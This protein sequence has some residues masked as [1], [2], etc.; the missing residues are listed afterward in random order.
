MVAN[1]QQKRGSGFDIMLGN[2]P[3]ER[4]KLQEKEWFATRHEAIATAS[5]AAKRKK[6]INALKTEDPPLHATFLEACRVAEGNSHALRDSGRYPL[7]GRGDVNTYTVFTE[8]FR[9]SLSPRGR[10]GCIV[11][12]GIATDDTTKFFFQ[13]I[14]DTQT[15]SSCLELENNGFF[16][17]A[18]QGH[19]VRFVLMT[20]CGPSIQVAQPTF[21][22]QGTSV[23]DLTN[24]DLQ[25]ILTPE[26]I[27]LLNPNTRTCPIFRTNRDAEIT[28]E[29]YRRV[30]VLVDE[31]KG[32]SGNPWGVKFS[33]MF[34]MSNDSHLF[35]TREDL[36]ADGWTLEGNVFVKGG[37]RMLPLY[38]AKFM[39]LDNHRSSDYSTLPGNHRRHILPK[40]TA[41]SLAD[42]SAEMIPYYWVSQ[43][44]VASQIPEDWKHQ[45][46]LGWRDVTDARASARTTVSTIV[47]LQGAGDKLLL[48][49]PGKGNY[50]RLAANLST[51]VFDYTSRQKVAGL[52]LKFFTMRQLPAVGPDLPRQAGTPSEDW[53]TNRQTELAATSMQLKRIS[54]PDATLVYRYTLTRRF[55]IRCELDAAFFHLYGIER[56]DVDYIMETFPIVKRKDIQKYNSYRTKDRILEIYDEMAQCMANGTQWESS[57][58]PPPGDPRAA[59]T[60]EELELWRAGNGEHLIEKYGLLDEET[61]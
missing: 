10:S 16:L 2:P 7:C 61:C 23:E 37:E 25:F 20:L 3:W 52:A 34:H 48:M 8:L 21:L 28:K 14:M 32:E 31:T 29:I 11:P 33:T 54:S 47:P 30:P 40:R 51:Y 58:D 38:E 42:P 50:L 24:E 45:W 43:I 5:N 15:L 17:D 19:M 46:M 55:Q 57:L 26:E 49:F 27:Q 18:G 59:W 56:D 36:E 44:D 6:L 22:F 60:E 35:H 13:D 53:F 9:N 12:S 4:V 39:H 1:D 41:E